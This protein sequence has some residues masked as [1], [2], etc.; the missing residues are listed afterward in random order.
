M[1][2]LYTLGIHLYNGVLRL[3]AMKNPKARKIVNG[4]RTIE[5]YLREKVTAKGG[6]WIWIHAASLGEF[7]QGRPLIEMLR[8]R[9]PDLKI[10]LTFFSPSGYE[11][12]RDYPMADAVSYMPFDT[13]RRVRRFL[14]I[15]NPEMAIFIKYEFWGNYL[16]ELKRRGTATYIIS[17]IFREK[18]IFF[19]P[20]GGEFRNMLRKFNRLYVQDEASKR[21][22]ADIGID[23]VTVAGDTRFDRVTSIVASAVDLPQIDR[24][25]SN[26]NPAGATLVAGSS[27]PADE[28]IIIPWLRRHPEV[29]AIF[30][31]HEF[32]R[33]RLHALEAS[34]SA[35]APC[36][37]LSRIN[38]GDIDPASLQYIIVDSFGL[39]AGLYRKA[40]LAYVGGGFGA[41]IH[42]INEAA[43]Y[44]IPVVFG[45][46]HQKF[47]EAS[48]LIA[49]GGAF[50]CSGD[51]TFAAAIDPL[52][53]DSDKRRQAGKAAGKYIADSIGA[54]QMIFDDLFGHNSPSANTL[55]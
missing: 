44:S 11:V 40:S 41:G 1:H 35:I 3:A 37:C 29:K 19:R 50:T 30:A 22:L 52:V 13:P 51:V 15:V 10:L 39:L 27:W 21:R 23:N 5:T 4:Q 47:K 53:S 25:N 33:V 36:R 9:R 2:P 14:D 24:F 17:A 55:S 49:R 32:D 54:T 7:E 42:N 28:A 26:V 48:D 20:W 34:L 31:P 12:R 46:R 45:P 43:A 6:R 38:D 16:T 8:N 18:Q